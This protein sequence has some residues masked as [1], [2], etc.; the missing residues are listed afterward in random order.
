MRSASGFAAVLGT[1]LAA[2]LPDVSAAAASPS[3][4]GGEKTITVLKTVRRLT[5]LGTIW[6]YYETWQSD[7]V[8]ID[9]A[10]ASV[11]VYNGRR[12]LPAS[13][14]GTPVY[15]IKKA[16]RVMG[17][18]FP[19][20][21]WRKPEF[22]DGDWVRHPGPLPN[23]YRSLALICLRGK[24]LVDDPARVSELGLS[25]KFQGGLVAYLNG[26]EVAR[27]GLPAG[28]IDNATLADA[29]PREAFVN[30]ASRPI[31]TPVEWP[32]RIIGA[33]E[34]FKRV[35]Y[36]WDEDRVRRYKLRARTLEV[37]VP[38]SALRKGLNVLA[39][40]I[41]RAPAEP[42][43]FTSLEMSGGNNNNIPSCWNR[44]ACEDL[45]LTAVAQAS[46]IRPNVAPPQ[47][48]QVWNEGVLARLGPMRY[49]DPG[50]SIRPIRLVGAKNGAYAGRVAVGRRSGLAGLRATMS[51]LTAG[52]ASIPAAAVQVLYEGFAA[53]T[54]SPT[55]FTE[56]APAKLGARHNGEDEE[57]GVP[58]A[59]LG[60]AVAD[61]AGNFQS[62]WVVVSVPLTAQA[63]TYA[64]TLSVQVADE[65][66]VAVPVEL[67]VVGDWVLPDPHDF[68][69]FIGVQESADSVAMQYNVP[70][71]S[72]E[73]WKH[74]DKVYELLAQIGTKD[75]YLPLVAKTH[76]ANEQSMVRWVKQAD[77]SHKHDFS[78][79]ER[80]LD[81]AV[82][83]LGKVPVVCLYLHDYGF[84]LESAKLPPIVPCVTELDPATG[85]L[86]ELKPP[87]WGTPEAQVFWR[88]VIDGVRAMLARRGLEKS[89][90]FGMAA[91]GWVL[92]QCCADLKSMY[93]DIRWVD[94]SHYY[95]STVGD[96]KVKQPVGLSASV[97]GV[98][99]IFYD[100]D[101]VGTRYG[102]RGSGQD[103]NI[104][105]PRLGNVPGAVF[106][107]Y[108]PTYRLFA[109]GSHLSG[110][111]RWKSARSSSGAGHIGADFWPVLKDPRGGP[112]RHMGNRYVFWHSL[113]ISEVIRAILSP[114]PSGPTAT[115]RL[116]IMR[117]SLQEA[118]ARIFVQNAVLDEETAVKL[119]AEL[120]RR[121][122]ELC[123]E[124]TQLIRYYSQFNEPAVR[125]DHAKVFSERRWQD[126]SGKLYQAASDVS[127][128]AGGRGGRQDRTQ[129]RVDGAADPLWL[130]TQRSAAVRP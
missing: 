121:C 92:R 72:E 17:S 108:L 73:H 31:P 83:H 3:R 93:P 22:D 77:G 54:L 50:G 129:G 44:A 63:G 120:L 5:D 95:Q 41:H 118:E 57:G 29:Y 52:G 91:N 117:E 36:G 9:G 6:R 55:A 40:E 102:W 4:A 1:L 78:V 98:V 109:E 115:A 128:A 75:I 39:I 96:G 123:D 12:K 90:M 42:V 23:Y 21:N 99:G 53:D 19:P 97:S 38:T 101:E 56:A 8:R 86:G 68:V 45:S 67:K 125:D 60:K 94:R 10:L 76:L 27:G 11:D 81:T 32:G 85:K 110:G 37:N 84:R 49:G 113:S 64:G 35:P 15:A 82:K 126:L 87:D 119:P 16:K 114:G 14:S 116:Q 70:L 122:K 20:G 65:K 47:G 103:R 130:G 111:A 30:A 61:A 43:M 58:I 105:F 69:T 74:L 28:R 7:V 89:V 124:R 104:N 88:P 13:G 59:R 18:P 25:I 33:H 71:W 79:L 26:Q 106:G 34:R 2:S 24:F 46:A 107:S 100:P 62:V 112:P 48:L 51:G 66:P 127:A 80:Y